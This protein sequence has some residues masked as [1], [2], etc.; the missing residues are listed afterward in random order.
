MTLRQVQAQLPGPDGFQTVTETY[1]SDSGQPFPVLPPLSL[2]PLDLPLFL[3]GAKGT[4]TFRYGVSSGPGGVKAAG[5]IGFDPSVEQ[6]ITVPKEEDVRCLLPED[7][8][9]DLAKKP[10]IEVR[11]K[12]SSSRVRQLWQPG[13]PWPVYCDNGIVTSR[14]I[15]VAELLEAAQP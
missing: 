7:Y 5:Q 11:L 10:P 3:S 15:T 1:R 12:T 13:L 8:T 2:P 9:K 6:E 14:L 4:E